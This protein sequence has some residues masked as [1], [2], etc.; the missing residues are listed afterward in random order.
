MKKTVC[1]LLLFFIITTI[2]FSQDNTDEPEKNPILTDKYQFGVGIFFP[3]KDFQLE[4]DG[5]SPNDEIEFGKALGFD[6]SELTFFLGFDWHFAKKWKLSGEYFGLRNRGD[7]VLDKDIQWEDYILEEG[8]NVSAGINFNIYRV[9]VGRI[10]TSGQK[11][12]FGGGLGFHFMNV[13]TFI[14]GDFLTSEGDISF[15]KS[16]KSITIPLPNLGLWY[17]YAPTTKL[18]LTARADVFAISINEFSGSLWD[19]TPGISYQFFDHF[20][21]AL[22]YRY[23][24]LGADFDTSDWH[25]G[26][27]LIFQGPSLTITGNF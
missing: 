21:A 8:T 25:G 6:N 20:G 9:Y 2:S 13:R 24:N 23:I 4:V 14:E 7:R 1:L 18:A 5:S 19:L 12:E 11:H 17:F 27:D 26:V 10:I 16:S 3:K 22:N 15:E